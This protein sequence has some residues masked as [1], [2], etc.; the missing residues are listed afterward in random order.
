MPGRRSRWVAAVVVAHGVAA[1]AG[2]ARWASYG[3]GVTT[4]ST[5]KLDVEVMTEAQ[6][7]T[8]DPRRVKIT[9]TRFTA[10]TPIPGHYRV[11]SE[12]TGETDP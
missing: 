9:L 8:A 11:I 3:A 7:Q 6:L 10:G 4:R 12:S 2:R 5:P 1:P